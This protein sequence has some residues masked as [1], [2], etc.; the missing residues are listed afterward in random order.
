MS[1]FRFASRFI[2]LAVSNRIILFLDQIPVQIFSTVLVLLALFI[3]DIGMLADVSD[4][5]QVYIDVCLI[6][7]SLMFGLE[8]LANIFCRYRVQW[9]VIVL[10]ILG[11]E[12]G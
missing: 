1:A 2:P 7:T 11:K 10:D 9:L 3:N 6:V 12:F 5:G 8:L 4:A